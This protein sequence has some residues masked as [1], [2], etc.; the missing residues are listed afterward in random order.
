MPSFCQGAVCRSTTNS[1]GR[2]AYFTL[3]GFTGGKD[4]TEK[5]TGVFRAGDDLAEFTFRQI[6]QRGE[7]QASAAATAGG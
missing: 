4:V 2:Y 1:Y 3:S 5:D 6:R 7:A